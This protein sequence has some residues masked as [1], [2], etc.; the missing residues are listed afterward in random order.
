[1]IKKVNEL[2]MAKRSSDRITPFAPPVLPQALQGP[3]CPMTSI[4]G[5]QALIGRETLDLRV[6][7]PP[8][9]PFPLDI[10]QNGE[11]RTLGSDLGFYFSFYL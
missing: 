11:E 7:A 9:I 2:Q 10:N 3:G 1:M 5:K 4:L 6:L 8:P